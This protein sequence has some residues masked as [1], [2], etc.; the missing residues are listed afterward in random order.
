[1]KSTPESGKKT[2]K[3]VP[4][5]NSPKSDSDP[6]PKGK[7]KLRKIRK[8]SSREILD[9]DFINANST[10]V[11]N[12]LLLSQ[13]VSMQ[14]R[15]VLSELWGSSNQSPQKLPRIT[16][17][18]TQQKKQQQEAAKDASVP[19]QD[20]QPNLENTKIHHKIKDTLQL[21]VVIPPFLKK[22]NTKPTDDEDEDDYSIDDAGD[23]GDFDVDMDRAAL[24]PIEQQDVASATVKSTE[25]LK[26]KDNSDETTTTT[27]ID[28]QEQHDAIEAPENVS[29]KTGEDDVSTSENMQIDVAEVTENVLAKADE[30]E[31]QNAVSASE[32]MSME[33][34]HDAVEATENVLANTDEEEDQDDVSASENMLIET[35]NEETT[36]PKTDEETCQD[37]VS[38]SQ[39]M[40]IE[41]QHDAIE[42]PGKVLVKTD[43]EE[44]QG[45]VSAS[46][47]KSEE[48]ST[49]ESDEQ[50]TMVEASKTD[51]EG[52]PVVVETPIKE[53]LI[54]IEAPVNITPM[55]MEEKTVNNDTSESV[56]NDNDVGEKTQESLS[57]LIPTEPMQAEESALP[58][59]VEPESEDIIMQE[60]PSSTKRVYGRPVVVIE[61]MGNMIPVE[62]EIDRIWFKSTMDCDASSSEEEQWLE[63]EDEHDSP[64]PFYHLISDIK[65]IPLETDPKILQKWKKSHQHKKG[66][67]P[68]EMTRR[69]T[70]ASSRRERL[71]A[72]LHQPYITKKKV[73]STWIVS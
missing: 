22:N 11:I 36:T 16:I 38:V 59:K 29:T 57:S 13:N 6:K 35:N 17:G 47:N 43:K 27:K 5:T 52:I 9:A 34:E 28:K 60:T 23:D 58:N 3:E 65:P 37:D 8:F 51:N 62:D 26:T 71:V 67:N 20:G 53:I 21:N 63:L 70:R 69:V 55:T 66:K 18:S 40:S 14:N 64:P 19:Q 12:E 73:K 32:N 49:P 1:M 4:Q 50:D 56:T 7:T 25:N 2:H 72:K 54:A 68:H 31:D 48:I 30:E 33:E 10:K 41:S 61:C 42:A 15:N 45:G 44:H 46:E 39:S 24:P